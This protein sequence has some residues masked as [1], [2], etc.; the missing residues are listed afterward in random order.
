M[1][2]FLDWVANLSLNVFFQGV[3]AQTHQ[4]RFH[5]NLEAVH[6]SFPPKAVKS[7]L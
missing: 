2:K 5:V 1:S 3:L 4:Q 6:F 7:N